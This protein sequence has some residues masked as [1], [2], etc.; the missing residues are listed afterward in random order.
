MKLTNINVVVTIEE[1]EEP[2]GN[3]MSMVFH[4]GTL[5]KVS[6]DFSTRMIRG[7]CLV[8]SYNDRLSNK[9]LPKPKK[10]VEYFSFD[11]P[12]VNVEFCLDGKETL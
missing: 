3:G 6:L 1:F 10:S 12:N 8:S 11:N 5:E 2:F 7:T 4:K 9:D